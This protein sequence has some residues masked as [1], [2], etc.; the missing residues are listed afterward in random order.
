MSNLD[1]APAREKF[2]TG[3]R[4]FG[5]ATLLATLP[6]VPLFSHGQIQGLRERYG[7]EY[8]RPRM[9]E[10]VDPGFQ[11]RH[12]LEI[13]PLLSRR[14]LF[15]DGALF[16]LLDFERNRREV[17]PAVFAYINGVGEQR[18]LVLFNHCNQP[19]IGRLRRSVPKKRDLSGACKVRREA[20]STLLNINEEKTVPSIWVDLR[21][22]ETIDMS[23]ELIGGDGLEVSLGAY[24]SKVWA[25]HH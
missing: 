9:E 2:G 8:S 14:A 1:E 11:A 22:G 6:G 21:T 4:Y 3:D 25:T 17:D 20:L 16:E 7:M 24:E 23:E 10:E 12:R 15:S 18:V 13:G 5:V 19:T